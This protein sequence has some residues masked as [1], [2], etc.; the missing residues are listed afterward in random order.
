MA[1]RLTSSVI[2]RN[3]CSRY[4]EPVV[5]HLL[6]FCD[7][8]RI[9]DDASTDGWQEALA[10]AWGKDGCRVAVKNH[11]PQ[12][13]NSEPA[14]YQH[15]AARQALLA[16]TLLGN[17]THIL[18]VDADELVSDG[19]AVRRACE[20][21]GDLFTLNVQEVWAAQPRGLFTREDGG[22]RAHEIGCL[23]RP[24]AFRSRPLAIRDH[25]H[26]TGRV[27]ALVNGTTRG[28]IRPVKVDSALLH[29][30]WCNVAEREMRYARYRDGDGGKFHASAHI[31]SIMAPPRK[32][33][34][35][36][37]AWPVALEPRKE[38]LLTRAGRS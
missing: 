2:V 36:Q 8:V 3:E 13:R 29:F 19:H 9:L 11:R 32:V 25:G 4:L 23:W 14:F 1:V 18:A 21:A 26:A 35:V 38:D 7:E 16:F 22:W 28:R 6:E 27:P 10:G 24:A 34:L 15:A 37:R 17:P 5:S 12:G 20:G 30:G 33:R 31:A